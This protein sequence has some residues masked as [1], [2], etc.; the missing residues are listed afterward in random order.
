[1]ALLGSAADDLHLFPVVGKF[2]ATVQA[3]HVGASKRCGLAAV[4]TRTNRD[5]EA[6]MAVPAPKERVEKPAYHQ[7]L[8][9]ALSSFLPLFTTVLSHHPLRF[10]YLG[11]G[12]SIGKTRKDVRS[13]V[14]WKPRLD[15]D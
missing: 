7:Q 12:S 2:L 1:M 14:L 8:H 3:D 9:R 15:N 11:K 10:H 13:F 4:G 5:R 6:V